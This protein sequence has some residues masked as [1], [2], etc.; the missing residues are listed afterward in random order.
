MEPEVEYVDPNLVASY[1][2]YAW[3]RHHNRYDQATWDALRDDIARDGF[4]E[5]AILS[6]NHNTGEAYFGEGNHR[7][8]IALELG[9][10][11]PV[12]VYRSTK[13]APDYPMKALTEPGEYSMRNQAGFSK[14]PQLAR[15]SDIGLPTLD[16]D[17]TI[18]PGRRLPS[19]GEGFEF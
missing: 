6:Y 10:P 9:I 5:P 12:V 14:F 11:L 13:T 3:S 1:R 8:G 15:P 19:S 2:E 4:R 17:A 18:E 7:I 16:R